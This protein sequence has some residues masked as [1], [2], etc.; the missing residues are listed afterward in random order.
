M[1]DLDNR[2]ELLSSSRP[3]IIGSIDRLKKHRVDLM[4][5][6]NQVE[7]DLKSEEQKLS[8]HPGTI[9]S[10]QEQR[11]SVVCQAQVLREQE[12]LIPSS[13]DAYRQEIET[14]DQRCLDLINAIHSLGLV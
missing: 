4:K 10:L 7:H 9:S 8:D 14:V 13:A 5:E 3:D 6:L 12:Q 2:I 1:A 11:D